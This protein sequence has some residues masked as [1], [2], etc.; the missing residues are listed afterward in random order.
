MAE[1]ETVESLQAEIDRA[2]ARKA[3][4]EARKSA[5]Q[6]RTAELAGRTG[7]AGSASASSGV[8]PFGA[9]IRAKATLYD[10]LRLRLETLEKAAGYDVA[11]LRFATVDAA[12]AFLTGWPAYS[13]EAH[14]SLAALELQGRALGIPSSDLSEVQAVLAAVIKVLDTH[15]PRLA[16]EQVRRTHYDAK[17]ASLLASQAKLLQ[18]CRQQRATLEGL[19]DADHIQEFCA[20]FRDNVGT[21]ETNFMVI[22]EMSED[23]VP[24][25]DVER[26][27]IEATEV[28]LAL[29]V[30]AY[31]RLRSTLL[32]VHHRSGLENACKL[33]SEF[34]ARLKTFLH[35]AERL[36]DMPTDDES[37]E[38]TKPVLDRCRQLIN[39]HGLH[40]V[41]ADHLSDFSLREECI[42]DHYSAIRRTIFSKLS[43]V[44]QSFQGQYS[45][46]RK[47]EYSDRLAE[48]NNWVEVK[49]K[50]DAWKELLGRVERM[51]ELIEENEASIGD[52]AGDS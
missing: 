9:Y 44:T 43:L 49:S 28:W 11:D 25:V 23:L 5:A 10:G 1:P 22:M 24:N 40:A 2:N 19:K 18:W 20:S 37:R 36:L 48:L 39:D 3:A 12:F 29:E 38:L 8:A 46:P 30:L 33:W 13:E 27:L 21:M 15:G 51:R 16:R 32:D 31:E 14:S 41:I 42:K 26:A 6:K 47:Q 50:S 52:G 17:V 7:D 45:Y 35:D 34:G 4:A